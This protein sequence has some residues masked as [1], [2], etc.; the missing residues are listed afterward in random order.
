MCDITEK[1]NKLNPGLQV[2][3]KIILQM[4]NNVFVFEDNLEI[5][6][7]EIQNLIPH[8]FPTLT[9]A[10]HDNIIISQ[11]NSITDLNHLA[12]LSNELQRRFLD[13][14]GLKYY[15]LL[16]ESPWH[17]EA[18]SITQLSPLVVSDCSKVF[19][20]FIELKNDKNVKV[21][22]KKSENKKNVWNFGI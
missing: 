15:F 17:S 10:R 4:A 16:I 7:K 11:T 18:T 20:E 2:V 14:R 22:L 21:F 1:L 12:P 3:N 9:K 19:D 5:Y 6:Y 13:L 8:N